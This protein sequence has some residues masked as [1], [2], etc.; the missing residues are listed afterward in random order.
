MWDKTVAPRQD[1]STSGRYVMT[2]SNS[3][4]SAPAPGATIGPVMSAAHL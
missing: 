3:S 1:L 2:H 4:P